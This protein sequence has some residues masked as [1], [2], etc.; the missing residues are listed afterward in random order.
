[1]YI[2]IEQLS[3]EKPLSFLFSPKQILQFMQFIIL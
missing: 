2:A 1:M 3:L